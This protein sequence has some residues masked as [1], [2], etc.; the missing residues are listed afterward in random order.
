MKIQHY[1][2][3]GEILKAYDAC[4]HASPNGNIYALSWYL[5]ITCPDWEILASE[6]FSSV[7]PLPVFR[8]HG[9]KHLRQPEFT[10]QLGVFSST[11]PD[12]EVVR[13]FL[14]RIPCRYR[15]KSLC[16][17][18]LN[19]VQIRDSKQFNSAEL[20]LI[21][22]YSYISGRYGAETRDALRKAAR[23]PLSSIGDVS[24]HDFIEFA[25]RF[26]RLN[27]SGL[28]P[29]QVK[30]LR[31]IASNAIRYRSGQIM[32]AFNALNQLVAAI[33]FLKF[34]GRISIGFAAADQEGIT[35][36]AVDFLLDRH[37]RENAEKNLVLGMDSCQEGGI[38]R[39]FSNFGATLST[40]PCL[41][42]L[43]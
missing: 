43:H 27:A 22:S 30:L 32:A 2:K 12:P 36:G 7:M 11:I 41:K 40:Y 42:N 8:S 18:K 25:Y 15:M 13:H 37:I 26:D 35:T 6:D 9:R 24:V 4:I 19:I 10:C 16:L 34:K 20:D 38:S 33:L 23:V 31:L 17:N 28:R 39:S 29:G 14:G 1:S 3:P 21:R 5:D